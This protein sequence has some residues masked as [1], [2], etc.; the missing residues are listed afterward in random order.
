MPAGLLG[1]AGLVGLIGLI[2]LIDLMGL[3]ACQTSAGRADGG[4]D[5]A[6][7]DAGDADGAGDTGDAGAGT[8]ELVVVLLN[9]HSFQE[10]PDSLA[11]LE[12]IGRGLAAL[13]ADLV[14]LNEVMSGTFWAYDFGGAQHDGAAIIEQALEQASGEQYHAAGCGFAHWD[15]GELMSNIVLSRTPIDTT[16]CRGLT[17]TDSWPAPEEQRNVTHARTTV[18]G[19]GP[20]GFFVTHTWGWDSADTLLQVEEVKAFMAERARGDEALMLLAGDL[21][22]TPDSQAYQ[23]W[24]SGPPLRLV[25]TFA[26]ANPEASHD[27]TVFDPRARIDYILVG[28]DRPPATDPAHLRSRLVFTGHPLPRVSD[29]L[30][31]MTVFRL[32]AEGG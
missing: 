27:P 18:P 5:A 19:L 25:D 4:R 3:V 14:G 16:G 30:G 6:A 22:I 9:T 12:R 8:V 20:V 21:N 7:Q 31:V 11:A 29:H 23:R 24:L 32:P 26:R 2:G 10:G 1:L 15:T 17:T 13:D 28:A